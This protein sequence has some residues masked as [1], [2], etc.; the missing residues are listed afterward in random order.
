MHD[1]EQGPDGDGGVRRVTERAY[2]ALF[3]TPEV[4]LSYRLM[5]QDLMLFDDA[6]DFL[7]S[8]A[9]QASVGGEG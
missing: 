3:P 5:T 8:V 7:F 2:V 1:F 9:S 6:V 4:L